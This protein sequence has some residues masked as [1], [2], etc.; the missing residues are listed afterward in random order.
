MR[1]I[2]DAATGVF[3]REKTTALSELFGLELKFTIDM[4][5]R[6]FSA[7]FKRRFLELN[8]FQKGTFLE[9]NSLDYSKT[10]CSICGF[11]IFLSAREGPKLTLLLSTWFDFIVQ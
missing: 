7:T 1:K 8:H 11:K 2:K 10:D 9:E 3:N 6:S 5:T 4:L